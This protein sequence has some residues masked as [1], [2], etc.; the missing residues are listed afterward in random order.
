MVDEAS[1]LVAAMQRAQHNEQQGEGDNAAQQDNGQ[2][3]K[4]A[5]NINN[6]NNP[7]AK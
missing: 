5:S 2:N 6:E 3:S 7:P 1:K 4:I